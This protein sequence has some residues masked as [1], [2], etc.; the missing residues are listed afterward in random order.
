MTPL[1]TRLATAM[2]GPELA[3]E[4]FRHGVRLLRQPLEWLRPA[5]ST[6]VTGTT[7][8][9]TPPNPDVV[10]SAACVDHCEADTRRLAA[11][12]LADLAH[13]AAVARL[14]DRPLLFLIGIGEEIRVVPGGHE[15]ASAWHEV[16]RH[17]ERL[18]DRLNTPV[19]SRLVHTDE[20]ALWKAVS[21]TAESDRS[22]LPND[23]LDGL[24]HLLDESAFPRGTPYTYFYDYYRAN[25][26]HYRRPVVEHVMGLCPDGVLIVENAQQIKAVAEARRLNGIWPTHHLVTLPAPG[27]FG[28]ERAT[29]SAGRDRILL[30]DLL[31]DPVKTL[32]GADPDVQ[33][34]WRSV[35]GLF[36]RSCSEG[37]LS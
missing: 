2:Y 15:L 30:A 9:S 4:M 34:F 27:R 28:G 16:A 6:F 36:E 1:T 37:S 10:V 17:V 22:D 21:T 11:T 25:V 29:R 33:V 23:R 32:D 26:A 12:V 19:G 3:Q 13:S 7:T 31:Q 35:I 24:Y 18:F 8:D 5:G 20:D 14:L